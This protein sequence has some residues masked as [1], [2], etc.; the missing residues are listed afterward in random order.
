[1]TDK[2][3]QAEPT[4]AQLAKDISF[5]ET[6]YCALTAIRVTDRTTWGT[7]DDVTEVPVNSIEV[8]E[9]P[10]GNVSGPANS[11]LICRG[12]AMLLEAGT[13]QEKKVAVFR[14][15]AAAASATGS[16]P[17][18]SGEPTAGAPDTPPTTSAPGAQGA[19]DEPTGGASGG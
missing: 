13:P 12:S 14:K 18:S 10:N 9:D 8:V 1:M 7:H 3:Y 11:T 5:Q 17:A 4:T 6:I 15:G 19:T 2:R 16:P